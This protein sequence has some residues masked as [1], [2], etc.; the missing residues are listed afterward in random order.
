MKIIISCIFLLSSLVSI[1]QEII[2]I[3][4]STANA[5]ETLDV[6]ITGL[7]T[8]FTQASSTSLR[9]GN[10]F[11][12]IGEYNQNLGAYFYQGSSSIVINGYNAIDNNTIVYN[13]TIPNNI[14]HGYY[15]FSMYTNDHS[16]LFGL[17]NALNINAPNSPKI[18]SITPQTINAGQTLNVTISGINTTFTQGSSTTFN[19]GN[20]FNREEVFNPATFSYFYQGSSSIVQNSFNATNDNSITYNL[21]VPNNIIGGNYD[22]SFYTNDHTQLYGIKNALNVNAPSAPKIASISPVSANAGETLDVTITGLN[23]TFLQG[24]STTLKI[25]NYFTPDQQYDPYGYY[26]T[27][28]SSSIIQNSF[29]VIDN[30]TIVYN[31]TIPNNAVGG[32]YDFSMYTNDHSQLFG[33]E[34]AF[35]VGPRP[36]PRIVSISPSLATAGQ[37]LNVSIIGENTHFTQGSST[38]IE[39]GF[40]PSNGVNSF[41]IINDTVIQANITVPTNVYSDFYDI[42]IGNDIDGDLYLFNTFEING[43]PCNVISDYSYLDN[44]GGNYS[45]TNNSTGNI[46]NVNWNFGDGDT[47]TNVNPSHTFSANG[48][49][50]V[51]LTITDSLS[52]NGYCFDYEAKLIHVTGVSAS[53]TCNAGFSIIPDITSNYVYVFNSSYGTNLSYFWDFGD[54]NYSS[55][56]YP[57]YSYNTVGPYNLCLYVYDGFGCNSFYC[58][59]IGVNGTVVRQSGFNINVYNPN[60]IG[61]ISNTSNLENEVS[62][63]PNPSNGLFTISLKEFNSKLSYIIT[64]LLGNNIQAKTIQTGKSTIDIRNLSA[65]IYFVKIEGYKPIRIIK[66]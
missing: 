31:I 50:I 48:D 19:I 8:T 7:N 4:P 17:K 28:G 39:F 32:Y 56:A 22:I 63:F 37:T 55:N 20:Y 46:V 66:E 57:N 25:E 60:S 12:Q 13:L 53:P 43:N 59:S 58:D 36:I 64:D 35:H 16:Q 40:N 61:L 26:F 34:N 62:I 14:I 24:S 3:S 21:T 18:A 11:N 9:I 30:N 42:Y 47:S 49:Y 2:S 51:V 1:S 27:Q 38:T 10:Y 54:G 65:G 44:G 33:L 6:T 29:N 5:G 41:N 45:F 52:V 23:T 15:D